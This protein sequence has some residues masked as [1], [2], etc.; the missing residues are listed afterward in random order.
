MIKQPASM[1]T[2]FQ[3]ELFTQQFERFL[4]KSHYPQSLAKQL[5][6]VYYPLASYC[7]KLHQNRPIVI[8]VN[9]TQGS[10]KS[11]LCSM[12]KW[13][14]SE[15]FNKKALVVS[16]DDLYLTKKERQ[17]LADNIH[18]LL[19]TRG[20]PG[21]HDVTLGAKIIK[22]LKNST[23]T[24]DFNCA[25][26]VFNKAIDDRAD[27][28]Q[29]QQITEQP[30]IIFLE[31]WC[32]NSQA[33][34]DCELDTPLNQ[35]EKDEDE[36]AIWRTWVNRQLRSVYPELFD[37]IDVN[38]LMKAPSF[39]HVVDWRVKQEQ[40]LKSLQGADAGMSNV[41]IERFI[42]HFQRIT[43]T[44]LLTLSKKSDAILEIDE[45][46]KVT[47]IALP[48]KPNEKF[49]HWLMYSDLDGSFLDHHDYNYQAALPAFNKLRQ[50]NIP[51][52]FNTSKTFAEVAA[53][54]IEL[55]NDAG[56]VIENGSMVCLPEHIKIPEYLLPDVQVNQ[57]ENYHLINLGTSVQTITSTLK[58]LK[59]QYAFK[60]TGFSEL[61]AIEV[62]ELTS[63]PLH[64][65]KLAKKRYASEPLV[66]QDTDKAL[67]KF[68]SELKK[69]KLTLL[70][71]GRFYHVLGEV[72]KAT[73]VNWLTQLYAI[74]NP[75]VNW[76]TLSAGDSPNDFA[77]LSETDIAICIRDAQGQHLELTS[78]NLQINPVTH[79]SQ[80]W[81]EGVM[82]ATDIILS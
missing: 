69:Q 66:W 7:N 31:G 44:N 43:E 76:N 21:T 27:A 42:Q 29:W 61:S 50:L 33:V 13:L 17:T 19:A 35:L 28:D 53:F 10:G 16:I 22:Q 48:H 5:H 40:R 59:Q 38:I 70:K 2:Q 32:V 78:S 67:K 63:L 79:G 8:G 54:N 30:D 46:Q 55:D 24:D 75:Y 51:V 4:N 11:T 1:D 3:S 71:G 34:N 25:I 49:T 15:A 58:S 80:G 20:V 6:G 9:G 23:A 62:A 56:F 26:P 64:K 14:L 41:E 45:H 82:Q 72:N 47:H 39:E 52:I 73:A 74:N 36:Y 68:S 12:L 65:A 60:F 57:Y 77:M 18:P 37:L 81:C